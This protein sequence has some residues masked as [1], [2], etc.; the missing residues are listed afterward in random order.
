[1]WI[2]VTVPAD[3]RPGDYKGTVTIAADGGAPVNVPLALRV[4][5][6]TLPDFRDFAAR[7]DLVQSSESVAMAYD[8]PPWSEAHFKLLDK[9]FSLLAPLADKTLYITGVR[10]THLGNEHAM[11][12]WFRGEDGELS[13]DFSVVEKYLQVAT[14]HLGKIPGVILY[15]WEPAESQGHAGIRIWDKPIL[16]TVVDKANGALSEAEGPAWGT[17]E[18]RAFWKKLTDGFAA[19]L[20]PG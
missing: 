11:I 9:T 13:P 6:W 17:P 20:R 7:M 2:T 4:I 10:R 19:L 3:A 5:D 12:R 18:C 1:M 16:I 14:R 15:V 8:V